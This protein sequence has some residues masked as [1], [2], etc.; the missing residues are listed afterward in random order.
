VQPFGQDVTVQFRAGPAPSGESQNGTAPTGQSGTAP[1][2]RKAAKKRR[3][4]R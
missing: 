1:V 3:P 2:A 4:P